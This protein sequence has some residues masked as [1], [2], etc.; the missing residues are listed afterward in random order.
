MVR[1]VYIMSAD[2]YISRGTGTALVQCLIGPGVGHICF[3]DS[4]EESSM[5]AGQNLGIVLLLSFN[6][7]T[8]IVL[9]GYGHGGHYKGTLP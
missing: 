8:N 6:L 2:H 3:V 4:T 9:A 5:M 7:L 1:A